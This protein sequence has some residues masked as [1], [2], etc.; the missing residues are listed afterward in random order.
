M[1]VARDPAMQEPENSPLVLDQ[2]SQRCVMVRDAL[3]YTTL[4]RWGRVA[5][6][7]ERP[8]LAAEVGVRQSTR[9]LINDG[10]GG[11]YVIDHSPSAPVRI[12][13]LAKRV[14]FRHAPAI[15]LSSM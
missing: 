3:G 2:P 1:T 14:K 9:I 12:N 8:G 4:P 13:R 7:R 6:S 11:M 15:E 10:L 5:F